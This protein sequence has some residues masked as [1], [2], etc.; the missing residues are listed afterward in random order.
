MVATPTAHERISA[1][2]VLIAIGAPSPVRAFRTMVQ[3]AA[4]PA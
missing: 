1:G 3:G 2:D 4:T